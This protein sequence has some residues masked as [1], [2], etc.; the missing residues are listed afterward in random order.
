MYM[1]FL[2]GTGGL[3]SAAGAGT[4]IVDQTSGDPTQTREMAAELAARDVHLVDAPVSGGAAGAD[5]GTIAIMVG[6]PEAAVARVRPILEEISPNIFVCGEIGA[7][8]VMKLVNNTVSATNRCAMLESVVMGLKN[9][10]DLQTITDVLNAGGARSRATEMM[11]PA[12][13]RGEPDAHFQLAL[14]LKDLNLSADLASKTGV[15]HQFGQM[16]RST[17]QSALNVLGPDANYFDISGYLA[18]V[19]GTEFKST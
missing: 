14:M 15:P 17:L 9:G 11:L 3:A 10:L 18:H 19:A 6:G 7:G 4:V 13:V 5:A 12:L 8:Q 16:T 2:F 1:R